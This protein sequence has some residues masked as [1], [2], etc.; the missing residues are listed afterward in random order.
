MLYCVN[1]PLVWSVFASLYFANIMYVNI[2]NVQVHLMNDLQIEKMK[3]KIV[4]ILEN[5]FYFSLGDKRYT[6][7]FREEEVEDQ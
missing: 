6:F 1:K 4:N 7:A 2:I 3:M 5:I